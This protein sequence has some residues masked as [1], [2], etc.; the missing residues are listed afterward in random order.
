MAIPINRIS[1]SMGPPLF[2]LKSNSF[3]PCNGINIILI[4]CIKADI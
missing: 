3:I 1:S 4:I 2:F